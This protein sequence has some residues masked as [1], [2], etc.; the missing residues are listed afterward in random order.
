M[1]GMTV[2]DL[3]GVRRIMRRLWMSW[4]NFVLKPEEDDKACP[5]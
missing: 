4:H 2:H 5:V 3:N 1:A